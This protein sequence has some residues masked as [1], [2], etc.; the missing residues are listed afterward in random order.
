MPGVVGCIVTKALVSFV[1]REVGPEGVT[2]ILQVAGRPREWLIA[3]P[4][5]HDPPADRTTRVM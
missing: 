5:V 4:H 3:E 2:A 1:E